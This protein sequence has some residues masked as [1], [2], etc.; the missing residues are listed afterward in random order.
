MRRRLFNDK[1]NPALGYEWNV[2]T[3]AMGPVDCLILE[4]ARYTR[5]TLAPLDS[6]RHRDGVW[7]S[8]KP[9]GW[10]GWL[11]GYLCVWVVCDFC[12]NGSIDDCDRAECMLHL[13]LV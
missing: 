3:F 11:A 6:S 1:N 7:G 4:V 9:F 12:L 10:A 2:M 13:D 8:V 5:D